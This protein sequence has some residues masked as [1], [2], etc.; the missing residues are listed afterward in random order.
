MIE[1]KK[2]WLHPAPWETVVSVNQALCSAKQEIH[3][4]NPKG[5][6]MARSLWEKSIPQTISLREALD[7]CRRCQD[8]GPFILFN[9]NTFTALGR[10]LLEDG[11]KLLPP[12]E[13]QIIRTTVSHYVA[14]MIGKR[15]LAQVLGHFEALWRQAAAAPPPRPV[16]DAAAQPHS[17]ATLT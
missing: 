17:T 11:L 1:L 14:G 2:Q 5:Y 16:T 13:A 8:L 3:Q 9:A 7:I 10:T 4:P 6:E 15:E 12:V